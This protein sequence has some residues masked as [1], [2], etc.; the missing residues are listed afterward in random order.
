MSC[1]L[2]STSFAILSHSDVS[3]VKGWLL[4]DNAACEDI[5]QPLVETVLTS[6]WGSRHVAQVTGY[7]WTYRRSERLSLKHVGEC[8]VNSR[9]SAVHLLWLR[10]FAISAGFFFILLTVHCVLQSDWLRDW[11]TWTVS[12]PRLCSPWQNPQC[13]RNFLRTRPKEKERCYIF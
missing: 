10:C 7:I 5:K 6:G 4:T 9:Y 3:W 12:A 8:T 2:A 13:R 11:P 1:A